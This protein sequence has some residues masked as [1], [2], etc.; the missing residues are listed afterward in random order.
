[1]L[2]ARRGDGERPQS[3]LA[4]AR[5]LPSIH[6]T[7]AANTSPGQRTCTSCSEEWGEAAAAAEG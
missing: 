5:V 1:M 4:E 7:T 6:G 3:Q 2:A